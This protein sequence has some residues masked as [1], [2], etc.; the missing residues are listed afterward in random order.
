MQGACAVLCHLWPVR[1]YHIFPHYL[2]NGTILGK[3]IIEH[4]MYVLIFSTSFVWKKFHSKK[5]SAT[6]YHKYRGL[7]V[8]YPLFLSD[9]NETWIFSTDF[10][11][12][13]KY[14]ISWKSVQRESS[15]TMWTDGQSDITKL[16]VAFHNFANAPNKI[17]S[18]KHSSILSVCLRCCELLLVHF[19]SL[20]RWMIGYEARRSGDWQRETEVFEK[21]N[22]SF[23]HSHISLGGNPS[24]CG[25]N[26][27][28]YFLIQK[29][30]VGCACLWQSYWTI[31]RE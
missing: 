31:V 7:H 20:G 5:N 1:L 17:S 19:P 2:I 3:N 16:L 23:C 11:K 8:K 22:L 24:F 6:H 4:E 15:C 30:P 27:V 21:K 13:L 12:I 14:H 26:S 28:Q 9:F 25:G 18:L 29:F 10:L